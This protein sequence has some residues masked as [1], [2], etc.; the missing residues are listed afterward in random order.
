MWSNVDSLILSSLLLLS[1]LFWELRVLKNTK[2]VNISIFL[3]AIL[4]LFQKCN[5]TL[6]YLLLL[7][8]LLC[9]NYEHTERIP[10]VL[11]P[12]F[13]KKWSQENCEYM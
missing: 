7:H 8:L 13:S 5:R 4:K 2:L 10:C 12:P 11:I 9:M 1:S 3:S 6:I